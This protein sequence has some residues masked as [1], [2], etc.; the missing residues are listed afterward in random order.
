[1]DAFQ[2]NQ[3]LFILAHSHRHP[4]ID[5]FNFNVQFTNT[6]VRRAE[7]DT[8]LIVSHTHTYNKKNHTHPKYYYNLVFSS[9]KK[10]IHY[11][12]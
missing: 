1:M 9:K 7:A 8:I 10:Q 4:I 12:T 6:I 11:I 3:I 5:H 2:F